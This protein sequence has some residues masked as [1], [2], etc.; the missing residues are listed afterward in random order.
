VV[1]LLS[2]AVFCSSLAFVFFTISTREIGISRTNVFSNLIPV[3]TAIFSFLILS[4]F[5]SLHKI[6]GIL[7]I[8]FGLYLSQIKERKKEVLE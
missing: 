3:F 8:V 7:L 1:S 4:E 6:L 2:L 5:F